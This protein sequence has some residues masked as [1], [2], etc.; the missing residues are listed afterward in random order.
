[1][2][3]P[4]RGQL[5]PD[6]IEQFLREARAAAQV[7][8]PNIVS[9]HE[10]GR[11]GDTVF[12]VNDFVAGASLR[13]WLTARR[14]TVRESAELCVKI[15]SALHA[16]HEAG[17][18]HRDLKPGNIMLDTSGEPRLTDFGLAKRE[19]G[20]I[21]MTVEGRILGTPAYMSPEQARGEAHQA[22]R[23]TDIYSLGVILF[24][25]LTG[26]LPF[27]GSERMLIVQILKDEPPRLR[28]L[29]SHI[30]RDLET[31]CL[32]CLEKTPAR[33]YA[34]AADVAAELHRYLD[35][36]PIQARPVGQTERARRWCQRNPVVA[37]LLA[38]VA[39]VL[40]LGTIVSA[41]FA[42]RASSEA[43]RAMT[44]KELAEQNAQEATKNA[45]RADAEAARAVRHALASYRRAADSLLSNARTLRHV[46]GPAGGKQEALEFI[47]QAANL[48]EQAETARSQLG[49]AASDIS[50]DEREFWNE[51]TRQLR[52][53]A[54]RWLTE[55]RCRLIREIALPVLASGPCLAAV[56]PEGTQIAVFGSS[57]DLSRRELL[58]LTAD[59]DIVHR[60]SL[61]AGVPL[62]SAGFVRD[63]RFTGANRV[64]CT[65]A[66][67]TWTWTLPDVNPKRSGPPDAPHT[68]QRAANSD[69]ND[70]YEATITQ[71]VMD[72]GWLLV[73]RVVG[74]SKV[75][76]LWKTQ[77]SYREVGDP[78]MQQGPRVAFG[79]DGR[80]LFV[81]GRDGLRLFDAATGQSVLP[82]GGPKRPL[83]VAK[84]DYVIGQSDGAAF[85]P[86]HEG[87]ALLEKGEGMD[88]WNLTLWKAEMPSVEIRGFPHTAA[89]KAMHLAGKSTLV[90]G[91]QDGIVRCLQGGEAS[92]SVGSPDDVRRLPMRGDAVNWYGFSSHDD[93]EVF[94]VERRPQEW[95]GSQQ[96]EIYAT[97]DGRLLRAFPDQ[98]VGRALAVSSNRRFAVVVAEE[99]EKELTLELWSIPK[100]RSIRPLG[101]SKA[102]QAFFSPKGNWLVLAKPV[103]GQ[104]EFIRLPEDVPSGVVK[105][106]IWRSCSCVF[107][108]ANGRVVLADDR[109]QVAKAALLFDLKSA[110]EIC[111]L[112]GLEF[113]LRGRFSTGDWLPTFSS[114]LAWGVIQGNNED[115]VRTVIWDLQNGKM[116][117]LGKNEWLHEHSTELSVVFSADETRALVLGSVDDS[118]LRSSRGF[119]HAELWDVTQ[120]KMLREYTS[121]VRETTSRIQCVSA[122]ADV[123]YLSQSSH[124]A[125][126]SGKDRMCW[127]WQDG[128]DVIS[129]HPDEALLWSEDRPLSK[130]LTGTK[131]GLAFFDK[132]SGKPVILGETS[133]DFSQT[134]GSREIRLSS[135]GRYLYCSIKQEKSAVCG[136]WD[137]TTGRRLAEFTDT[138]K[139]FGFS[140]S[141][142]RYVTASTSGI[143]LWDLPS[144]QALNSF[145]PPWWFSPASAL[146]YHEPA[147][148]WYGSSAST[149]L[150][151][152]HRGDRLC[153]QCKGSVML[154]DPTTN[155]LLVEV[156]R[157]GHNR[158]ITA[159]AHHENALLVVS[160]DDS[161]MLLLWDLRNG[162]FVR[163]INAHQR[164][165]REIVFAAS[166]QQF[167]SLSDDSEVAAWDSQGR[168][169]WRC[170]GEETGL[171]F[172]RLAV[173]PTSGSLVLG[174]EQGV[175]VFLT[176]DSGKH[177][178]VVCSDVRGI[179][180]LCFSSEIGR[181]SCRER[182]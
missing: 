25:L 77:L 5:D 159:V 164:A 54:V 98:G 135:D 63:L 38:T 79:T 179:S 103:M 172:R 146:Q 153:V 95:R 66:F 68:T 21:T 18:I 97:T 57:S 49:S 105:M 100:L 9:V 51:C 163:S 19:A 166:G 156:R 8:H 12:I 109:W 82:A 30:P 44:Q 112:Q 131:N 34:T 92:W 121:S 110:K 91:S 41:H 69:R 99:S 32:K 129:P 28:K 162:R 176:A 90:T 143:T 96:T 169:L 94:L 33:R 136:L 137:A 50:E 65:T 119:P 2:K 106:P 3:I 42:V 13:D 84:R 11:E 71:G 152:N 118:S 46:T 128:S 158:A 107:D 6:G 115:R 7:Q 43:G 36:E 170:R 22:D 134:A 58:V 167:T 130:K 102:C 108:E 161:G 16:A 168:C 126:D 171:H 74:P 10:V 53:E 154:W 111:T 132:R 127:S 39:A 89:V 55:M 40:L 151:L 23:R 182:V 14:L 144:S 17:V 122:T 116:T 142:G 113:P 114:R 78:F 1:M 37:G 70:R 177:Q 174:S 133:G 140:G 120:P 123:A 165:V 173:H 86:F 61:P 175:V 47:R 48:R 178:G 59:G 27:R 148:A 76:Q 52:N 125:G 72:G 24:E 139:L 26:E 31:I 150:M 181:A 45:A 56:N 87:V 75:E 20:E 73:Q 64:V 93:D 160:A 104:A 60:L 147:Y 80:A 81:L 141:A 62:V 157:S 155:R 101:K 83:P 88:R 138:P 145:K 15:A 124:G 29:D 85:A 180:A 117:Q 4:R 149:S 67:E 35:G